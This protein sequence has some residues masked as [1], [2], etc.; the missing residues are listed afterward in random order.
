MI[1]TASTLFQTSPIPNT[2]PYLI[3]G[4]V[5]IGG[6][7]LGYVLSL[8]FRQRKLRRD[9]VVLDRLLEDDQD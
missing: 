9:L 6:V 4:Y 8:M 5:I 3:L 7:G 2:I 1:A